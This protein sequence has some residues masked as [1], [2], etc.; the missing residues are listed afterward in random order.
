MGY[1]AYDIDQYIKSY[2]GSQATAQI[3]PH[4]ACR[5]TNAA[6][7]DEYDAA[8]EETQTYDILAIAEIERLELEREHRDFADKQETE[9]QDKE[10]QEQGIHHRT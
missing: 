5:G 3:L 6:D 4:M 9:H 2:R 1:V 7:S 8:R 10:Q